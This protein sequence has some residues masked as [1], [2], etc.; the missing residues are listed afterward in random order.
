MQA[1]PRPGLSLRAADWRFLLPPTSR[2][3]FGHLVLLGGSSDLAAL[4][5]RLEVARRVS[6]ALPCAEPADAVVMLAHAPE[7]L[8]DAVRPLAADGVLYCEIDRRRAR[9]V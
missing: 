6:V 7:S 8:D 3:R 4:L 5:V 1:C 9:H 2:G